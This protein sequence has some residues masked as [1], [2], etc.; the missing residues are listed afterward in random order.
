MVID[1]IDV[2]RIEDGRFVEH[3]GGPDLVALH[4]QLGLPLPSAA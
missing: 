2:V 3:W 1:L 4:Q